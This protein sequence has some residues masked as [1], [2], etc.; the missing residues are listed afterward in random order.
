MYEMWRNS[1][2]KILKETLHMLSIHQREDM[3]NRDSLECQ[4]NERQ[5]VISILESAKNKLESYFGSQ[6]HIDCY[7]HT[8]GLCSCSS[9]NQCAHDW[10]HN[11]VYKNIKDVKS[12]MKCQICGV[13]K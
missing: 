9:I 6:H 1:L 4:L 5:Y 12:F 2:N 7:S 10:I 3:K 13:E 11:T 8:G